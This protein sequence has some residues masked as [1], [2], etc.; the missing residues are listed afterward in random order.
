M[1]SIF[2]R[3]ILVRDLLEKVTGTVGKIIDNIHPAYR[4]VAGELKIGVKVSLNK[5]NEVVVN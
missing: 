3:E 2:S 1:M 5:N 4:V